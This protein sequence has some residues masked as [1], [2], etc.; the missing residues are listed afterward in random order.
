MKRTQIALL[1]LS[2]TCGISIPARAQRGVGETAGVAQQAVKPTTVS[3]SGTVLEVKTGPC[4]NTTGR[5]PLGTHFL[6]KTEEGET[7]NIHLGPAVRVEFIAK[8]LPAGTKVKVEGFRTEK[9]E[10]GH[11]AA[12]SLTYG[13]RTVQLRGGNLQPIWAG[14]AGGRNAAVGAAAGFGRGRGQGAGYGYRGGRGYGRQGGR[15]SGW[16]CPYYRDCGEAFR[17]LDW[18]GQD[19]G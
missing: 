3:L 15:G 16:G 17:R 5:S 7:L 8:D 2:I 9:M 19:A 6:M 11:Y 18:L 13:D 12:V 1:A 14:G 4:E 10:P